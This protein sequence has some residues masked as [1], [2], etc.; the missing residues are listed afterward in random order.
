MGELLSVDFARLQ[1]D[2]EALAE[3][4]RSPTDQGLYRP[5][6][7][8]E[9]LE[10]QQWFRGRIEAAG[11]ECYVDSALNMHGRLNYDGKRPSVMCGS[12]LDSVPGG[13][14]L[15]GAL[16]VVAGLECLRRLRELGLPTKYALE[17]VSFSDE[18][19]RFGGMFGSRAISGQLTPETLVNARDLKGIQLVD[20]LEELGVNPRHALR[21]NRRPESVRGFVELHIEQ[22]PVLD[23]AGQ[24]IGVVDG[25]CGLFKWGA[26]L[27]GQANHAGTTPMS[28]RLDA[29]QGLAEFAGQIDRI[30]EEDGSDMSVAT[31]GRVE[32][33][34]G[35]PNVVP[36]RVDFTLEV[37]DLDPDVLL[38]LANGMRR[39]ISAIARRRRLM[40]DFEVL[41]EIDPVR[42]DPTIRET[43]ENAASRLGV[44]YGCLPSGAAHDAQMMADLTPV[45]MIFVPSKEGRSHSAAEWTS[46]ESIEL[47]AN[48]LLNSLYGLATA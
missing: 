5:A 16:G 30:L 21:S 11:L 4:G 28:M 38:D 22:G 18:E 3:I 12:H 10:A 19:G 2:L 6:F 43:I 26:R 36:G 40:F 47:G 23:R 48:C 15:D 17:V 13:G 14:T 20:V 32:L 41:S 1:S 7:S 35:A 45:G 42:C 39:A 31:I 33:H 37:R 8:P 9:W 29:F 27:R 24:H 44:E 34:P 25:I 46:W